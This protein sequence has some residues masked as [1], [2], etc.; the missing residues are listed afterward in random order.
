MEESTDNDSNNSSETKYTSYIYAFGK[1]FAKVD[2]ILDSTIYYSRKYIL[3][4]P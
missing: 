2:G 4:P 3:F 1:T